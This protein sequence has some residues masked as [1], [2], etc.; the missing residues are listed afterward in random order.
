MALFSLRDALRWFNGGD[1]KKESLF[2]SEREA[3]DFCR[4]VYN[5][6]GGATAELR[7]SYEFYLKNY[8]DGCEPFVGPSKH[9]DF[10]HSR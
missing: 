2:K 9:S 10:S 8:D 4:S 6:T 1:Q 5:E 7:R 3:Y